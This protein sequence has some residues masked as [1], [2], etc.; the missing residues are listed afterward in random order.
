MRNV[1][2]GTFS[3]KIVFPLLALLAALFVLVLISPPGIIAWA[4]KPFL[5]LLPER[6][7]NPPGL[8]RTLL[9]L[10]ALRF[11]LFPVITLIFVA[12]H[13]SFK[14]VFRLLKSS[15]LQLANGDG[16]ISRGLERV[17]LISTILRCFRVSEY[18][19]RRKYP[20]WPP[21][22]ND[23]REQLQLKESTYAAVLGKEN[24]ARVRAVTLWYL[25]CFA[26]VLALFCSPLMKKFLDARNHIILG[27]ALA[28]LAVFGL[29]LLLDLHHKAL[30]TDL[31]RIGSLMLLLVQETDS[32]PIRTWNDY[33]VNR[34]FAGPFLAPV[35]HLSGVLTTI[36]AAHTRSIQYAREHN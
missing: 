25:S 19:M 35:K 1:A 26:L 14:F 30:P 5:K 11:F 24:G 16:Q 36:T 31:R 10:L 33:A 18:R 15:Q 27:L 28:Y 7:P 22:E 4:A 34:D 8:Q 20:E 17:P 6:N 9:N 23:R 3:Q 2:V 13:E 21:R 29:A 32:G 12:I